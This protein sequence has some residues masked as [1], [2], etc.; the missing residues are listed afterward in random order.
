MA[1]KITLP[2]RCGKVACYAPRESYPQAGR[3]S[4]CPM[5]SLH[6]IEGET[7]RS[8]H[9][10]GQ[11][12][13]PPRIFPS[14]RTVSRLSVSSDAVAVWRTPT[15]SMSVS[16]IALDRFGMRAVRLRRVSASVGGRFPGGGTHLS[17]ETMPG[18]RYATHPAAPS[19]AGV[20]SVVGSAALGVLVCDSPARHRLWSAASRG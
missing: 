16:F 10:F 2:Q 17:P 11:W 18:W 6:K 13:C 20:A 9:R 19:A 8:C 14:P 7:T 4:K 15:S 5:M 3:K 12:S 1:D